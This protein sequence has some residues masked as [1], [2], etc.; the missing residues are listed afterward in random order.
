MLLSHL[1]VA[2]K[3]RFGKFISPYWKERAWGQ[4]AYAGAIGARSRVRGVQRSLST[5]LTACPH[6]THPKHN[7]N[8]AESCTCNHSCGYR[9]KAWAVSWAVHELVHMKTPCTH[10]H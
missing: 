6:P 4:T 7:S 8:C 1:F 9:P 3:L 5:R 2:W 10:R